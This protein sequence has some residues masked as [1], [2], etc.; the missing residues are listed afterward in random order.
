[1]QDART[2]ES[3]LCC[4]SLLAKGRC[5]TSG[6]RPS[7][8]VQGLSHSPPAGF[9]FTGTRYMRVGTANSPRTKPA[10]WWQ[11]TPVTQVCKLSC[12]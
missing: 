10:G 7:R 12:G 5:D 2:M 6:T 1:M 4:G 9:C 3:S 8:P 11:L